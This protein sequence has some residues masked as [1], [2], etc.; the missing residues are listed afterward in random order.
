[1]VLTVPAFQNFG[2]ANE[3][4]AAGNQI[5]GLAS[6]ARQNSI[7]RGALTLLLIAE[8]GDVSHRSATLYEL[9]PREDGS[10]LQPKDWKQISRWMILPTGIV[11][12]T[13]SSATTMANQA[14]A[15]VPPLPPIN[16]QNTT[17]GRYRMLVFKSDG[18]LLPIGNIAVPQLRLVE[19]T[20]EGATQ[21][22]YTRDNGTTSFYN[23]LF[24]PASG[25]LKIERS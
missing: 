12:D 9:R 3:L 7:T 13:A 14:T 17:V 23:I 19:G 8:D 24:L 16:Y 11:V 20:S 21:I 5:A 2:R 10:S 6:Q 22:R 18:S 4:T 15:L 25:R 1:M